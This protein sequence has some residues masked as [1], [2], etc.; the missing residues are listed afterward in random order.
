MRRKN[1]TVPDGPASDEIACE[2]GGRLLNKLCNTAGAIA[3]H[4]TGDNVAKLGIDFVWF[5]AHQQK[6]LKTPCEQGRC[7]AQGG[8]EWW[9]VTYVVIRGQEHDPRVC[10][11]LDDM[12]DA[13]QYAIGGAA[14]TWLDDHIFWRQRAE[15]GA[16]ISLVLPSHDR[17]NPAARDDLQRSLERLVQQRV[18]AVQRT[19]LLGYPIAALVNGEFREPRAVAG[20]EHNSPGLLAR[21][22]EVTPSSVG[23]QASDRFQPNARYMRPGSYSPHVMAPLQVA[24][25][26]PRGPGRC[27]INLRSELGPG[28]LDPAWRSGASSQPHRDP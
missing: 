18:A 24:M 3:N 12:K 2:R 16:P 20:C 5:N 27:A 22:H 13:M 14:V 10:I 28:G 21:L 15:C 26:D 7:R 9:L 6:T 23:T 11:A 25:D 1:K 8:G 19:E 4:R 17:A